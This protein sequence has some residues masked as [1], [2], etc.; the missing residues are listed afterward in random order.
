MSSR[1]YCFEKLE[2]IYNIRQFDVFC[3]ILILDDTFSGSM[4]NRCAT[5]ALDFVISETVLNITLI[6]SHVLSSNSKDF[7]DILS[8]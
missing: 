1:G 7:V 5:P 8:S 3:A 6:E 4:D 2:L